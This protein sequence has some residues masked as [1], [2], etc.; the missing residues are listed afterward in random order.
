M[1]TDQLVSL[2]KEL[3]DI[4]NTLGLGWAI[5]LTLMILGFI[6]VYQYLSKTIT[7]QAEQFYNQ[8]LESFKGDI[9]KTI[10]E[11][12]VTHHNKL[13]IS[14]ADHKSNL[15]KSLLLIKTNLNVLSDKQIQN[16]NEERKSIIEFIEAYSEWLYGSIDTYFFNFR[17]LGI[18]EIINQ[19]KEIGI[20]TSKSNI[21]YNKLRFWSQDSG[22]S[23]L[24]HN[25]R[26][27]LLELS[28]KLNRVLLNLN[29]KLLRKELIIKRSSKLSENALQNKIVI[30]EIDLEIQ[31]LESECETLIIDFYN[32]KNNVWDGILEANLKFH[33]AARD[34]LIKAK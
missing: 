23:D 5:L 1:N 28:H 32:H 26:M 34:Y 10:G 9:Y 16:Q 27:E 33:E 14:L 18:E 24:A 20:S 21:A 7:K 31:K 22:L 30:E 25:I 19:I 4:R 17:V 11:Q 8:N 3:S 6:I 12:L 2:I 15:D 13:N 29:N